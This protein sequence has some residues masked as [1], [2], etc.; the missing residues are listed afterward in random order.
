M[1]ETVKIIIA[2]IVGVAAGYFLHAI[3]QPCSQRQVS[4]GKE[5]IT[6]KT[7]SNYVK[8]KTVEKLEV[9]SQ[10]SEEIL[11][12]VTGD[13][14]YSVFKKTIETE[15]SKELIEITTFP[16][17]DSILLKRLASV[18]YRS[19]ERVDTLFINRVDTLK[20]TEV[21]EEPRAFYDNFW[22]GSSVTAIL[23]LAITLLING[24]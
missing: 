18:E 24:I 9:R 2:V 8:G 14:S 15:Y 10:K 21:I 19:A 4:S 3:M 16:A 13:S 5:L 1:S 23:I 17:V 11:K 20:Q 7:D 12:P 6:G 22:A